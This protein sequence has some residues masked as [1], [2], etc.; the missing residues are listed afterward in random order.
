MTELLDG[1]HRRRRP[2]ST[3]RRREVDSIAAR[4]E[5]ARAAG[6]ASPSARSTL[7]RTEPRQH[8]HPRAV[9][10]RRDFEGRA[11]RRNG[12][13]GVGRRRLHAHRHLHDRRHALARDRSGR[14]RELHQPRAGRPAGDGGARRVSRT[15]RFPA[16]VITMVPTADRQKATVLVRIGFE[17]L[18]PRILPDMG[19]KVTFLREAGRG[20]RRAGAQ[21]VALVPKTA[22]RT[23]GGAVVRL[24]RRAAT[25]SSGARSRRAAPTAIASKC[26]PASRPAIASSSSPPADARPT[27][28]KVDREV[29]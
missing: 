20:R 25:P 21:P 4:I 2:T 9:Q 3:R 28:M 18:D 15:G 22:I 10:R 6:R 5:A 16:H 1:R 29:E 19:V 23:D 7:Q 14:Q 26:S 11:A 12:L 8:G 27:G 24:R 17:K 13:A